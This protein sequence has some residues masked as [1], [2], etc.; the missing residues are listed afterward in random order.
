[1]S[2]AFILRFQ[3]SIP[4]IIDHSNSGTSTITKVQAEQ[5]DADPS[6]R[7]Y[8]SLRSGDTNAGTGTITAVDSEQ[9]DSDASREQSNAIPVER[10]RIRM[11]T[12]TSTLI[13]A[14]AAD[15]VAAV[16]GYRAIRR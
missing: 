3:E 4:E 15:E 16:Q 10:D 12:Q 8:N 13:K 6:T 14:E 1:M 9:I 5:A 7:K 2:I 11:G